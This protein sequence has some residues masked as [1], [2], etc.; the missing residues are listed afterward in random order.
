MAPKKKSPKKK[1]PKRMTTTKKPAAAKEQGPAFR[2]VRDRTL[3]LWQSAAEEV[4]ARSAAPKAAAAGV[5][6]APRIA[7]ADDAPALDLEAARALDR[8]AAATA[9]AVALAGE[10]PA[11]TAI[12]SSLAAAAVGGT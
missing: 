10:E 5:V 3:S 4:A 1:G 2:A 11:A 7:A 8:P 9:L 12:A 6:M